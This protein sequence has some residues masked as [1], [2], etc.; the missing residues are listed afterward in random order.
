MVKEDA[1]VAV[2]LYDTYIRQDEFFQVIG[3][4]ADV[5]VS[6]GQAFV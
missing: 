3:I 5:Q 4:V 2:R 6:Q 1:A